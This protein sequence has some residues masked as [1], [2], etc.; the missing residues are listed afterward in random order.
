MVVQQSAGNKILIVDDQSGIRMLLTEVLEAGGYISLQAANGAQALSVLE[1][2]QPDLVLLDMKI[3][4]MN[5]ID[6]LKQIN[7]RRQPPKVLVM[8]AYGEMDLMTEALNNGAC[9]YISKPFDI[10][11]VMALIKETLL[12]SSA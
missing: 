7:E 10:N 5:G 1:Q 2:N 11:D 8:S 12:S 3:P 4:G 9:N 6:V